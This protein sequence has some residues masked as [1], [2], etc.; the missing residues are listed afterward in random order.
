MCA[1]DY[2]AGYDWREVLPEQSIPVGL[3]VMASL[4]EGVPTIARV[5]GK[6]RLE[7]KV[8]VGWGKA[9]AY[10]KMDVERKTTVDEVIAEVVS[11]HPGVFPAETRVRL[12][13]DGVPWDVDKGAQTV[14]Q[15]K[16]FGR[17]VSCSR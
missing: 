5:P 6:W 17:K 1:G 3:E 10:I 8:E 16:L 11:K 9:A 13:V 4:E 15:A 12:A 7:V 14:E 2:Q